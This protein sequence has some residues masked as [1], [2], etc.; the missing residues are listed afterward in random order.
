METTGEM[1]LCGEDPIGVAISTAGEEEEETK[2]SEDGEDEEDHVED[3]TTWVVR[4]YLMLLLNV[5]LYF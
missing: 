3:I 4:S 1:T 2:D 5:L